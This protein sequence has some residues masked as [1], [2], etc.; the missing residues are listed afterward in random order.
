MFIYKRLAIYGL[1]LW[2]SATIALRIWGHG[3]FSVR[4]PLSIV[5][6]FAV[7]VVLMALV[8]RRLCRRFGVPREHWLEGALALALP[9]L[10]LDP[11]SCA[12]FPSVFPNAPI[13]SAGFFG[14]WMLCCCCGALAGE[15]RWDRKEA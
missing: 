10:V 3:I 12:F 5:V 13:E 8:A 4:S 9:T 15:A 14:G 11:F 2:L 6:V 7:S 1:V